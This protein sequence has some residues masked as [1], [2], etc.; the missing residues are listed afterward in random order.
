MSYL[1]FG[2][3]SLAI[4]YIINSSEK[5]LFKLFLIY[6]IIFCLLILDG[7]FQYFNGYNILGFKLST[8]PRVSSFFGDELVLGGYLSRSFPVYFALYLYFFEDLTKF[9]R[10]IGIILFV[11]IEILIFLS[12]E[13]SAFFFFNLFAVFVLFFTKRLKNFRGIFTVGAV[14]ILIIISNAFS[15]STQRIFHMTLDQMNITNEKKFVFFS[16]QHNE[17]YNT[18][19]RITKDNLITGVGIK[20]FRKFCSDPKYSRSPESC[21]THPHNT[22]IQLLV[23][24]GLTGF[25]FGL[26]VLFFLFKVLFVHYFNNFFN[27]KPFDDFQISLLGGMLIILWPFS[28]SGNIFNNWLNIIYFYPFSILMWSFYKKKAD[29]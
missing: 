6:Q 16:R 27:K 26:F 4:I 23:E 17:L 15:N 9:Y 2:I 14:L 10:Y 19:I 25:A 11:L 18:A 20:N 28:P 12:G 13:R 29:K 1:R 8:G 24:L 21:S 5:I 22:Y 7:F 3:F